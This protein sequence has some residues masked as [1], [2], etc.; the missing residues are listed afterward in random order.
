MRN[1]LP[2]YF[3]PAALLLLSGCG[4]EG[5]E[6]FGNSQKFQQDFH[7]T[8]NLTPGG[9]LSIENTNGSI[10]IIGWEKNSVDISGTKYAATEELMNEIKVDIAASPSEIR[11]RTV[12]PT[13]RRGNLGARYMI[14]VPFRTVLDRIESSNG[15]VRAENVEGPARLHTSNG[16]VKAF[17]LRGE[18]EVVTSNGSVEATD[19]EG[20][21]N[22]RTSNGSVTVENLRGTLEASTSNGRIRARVAQVEPGKPLR[23]STSNGSI[24]LTLDSFKD[25]DVRASTS[26]G[27]ITVRLPASLNARLRAGTSNSTVTSDFDVLVKGGTHSKTRLDGNVGN[28]GALIDLTS[29]NGSIKILKQ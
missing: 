9:R 22:V 5:L 25:N 7:H 20:N 17:K 8:Y 11:V 4:I 2:T 6:G 27:S 28:G 19:T 24:E 29:T 18:L 21:A 26:N 16:S 12:P 15:S 1:R 10:E 14:R 3:L 13:G 23:A